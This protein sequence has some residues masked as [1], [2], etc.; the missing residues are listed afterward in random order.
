MPD[1]VHIFGR[2]VPKKTLLIGGGLIAAAVAVVV[3]LRARAASAAAAQPAP[4][5]QPDTSGG[6]GGMTVAAPTQAAADQYQQGITQDQLA[7][8]EQAAQYANNLALQ[9][10]Q[11][12]QLLSNPAY[13]FQQAENA[14]AA[15]FAS[16]PLSE[17]TPTGVIQQSWKQFLLNGQTI[18]ED[19]SGKSRAPIT[20]TFAEQVGAQAKG[21]GPYYQSK[22]GGFLQPIINATAS[23]FKGV[24]GGAASAEQTAAQAYFRQSGVPYQAP[25]TS[26]PAPATNYSYSPSFGTPPI[27]APPLAAPASPAASIA[28]THA[29]PHGY[30]EIVA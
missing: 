20:E 2:E 9:Q 16:N 11:Q 5:P 23:I 1:T 18:W 28:S 21:E 12:Q 25:G 8:A 26:A 15:F 10:A 30:Q 7:A 4:A 19:V 17:A 14:N 27:I 22:G 3:W 6:G 29:A 13:S 24:V